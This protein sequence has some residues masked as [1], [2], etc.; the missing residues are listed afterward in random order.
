MIS[1]SRLTREYHASSEAE[2]LPVN[3]D[4]LDE[5]RVLT[6]QELAILVDKC[7]QPQFVLKS[8]ESQ[9]DICTHPKNYQKQASEVTTL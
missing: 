9:S 6:N 3:Y 5:V 4:S 8:S 7:V 1:C 2:D